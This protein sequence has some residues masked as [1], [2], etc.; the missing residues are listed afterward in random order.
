MKLCE[1]RLP[2]VR[3]DRTDG[4]LEQAHHGKPS[5]RVRRRIFATLPDDGHLN[6]MI[7]E[8]AVGWRSV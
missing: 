7:E 8:Y 2:R 1:S 5:F 6:V 3:A 4:A